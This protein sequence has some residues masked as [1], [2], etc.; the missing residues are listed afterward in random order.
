MSLLAFKMFLDVDCVDHKG[1]TFSNGEQWHPNKLQMCTCNKGNVTCK[2]NATGCWDRLGTARTTHDVWLEEEGR[3]VCLCNSGKP[4]CKE[5]K[6]QVCLDDKNI[7]R[8]QRSQW[9]KSNCTKCTCNNGRISCL[10][11]NIKA[12]YGRFVVKT[13]TC[14][15]DSE[16]RCSISNETTRDCNGKLQKKCLCFEREIS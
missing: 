8:T 9:F 15:V 5:Y 10:R 2:T 12:F 3:S 7:V 16:P 6:S 1:T 4:S 11:H 13:K 14:Y